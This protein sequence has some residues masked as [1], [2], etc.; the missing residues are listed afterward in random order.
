[1]IAN[2]MV[3]PVGVVALLIQLGILGNIRLLRGMTDLILLVII[4]WS[5]QERVQNAWVWAIVLG[6]AV[7]FISATPL[8]LYL[9]GYLLVVGLIRFYHRRLQQIPLLAM[10]LVTFVG[11][12]IMQMLILITLQIMGYGIGY[13]ESMGQV[14]LPSV[15]LN[16]FFALPV[17][18]LMRD[19]S[20]WVY[21]SELEV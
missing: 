6:G 9:L 12:V 13:F 14:I 2:L 8:P 5:I 16:I 18:I 19:I 4:A 11:T 21:P 7:S 17:F 1:M 15:L 20:R 3:L 10:L